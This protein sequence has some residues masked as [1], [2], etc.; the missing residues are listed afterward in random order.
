MRKQKRLE[1]AS[2]SIPERTKSR[3]LVEEMESSFL[4]YSMSVI[5]H[6]AL[7]DVRDG[8]KPVHRRILYAMHDLGLKPGQPYKKSAT[9]VGEV[10]GKYH[11]HGDSAVYEAMVRLAQ[12]FVMAHPL[13]D[14][15]GN[16]GSIDGDSAA[17]YRYTEVRLS[18]AAIAMLEDIERDTVDF[19]PNFDGR[20]EEP[21]VL[22]AR[23][24][25]LLLNGSE[26][27]AVGMATKV[28]PHNLR[29]LGAAIAMLCDQP[30]AAPEDVIRPIKGPDFPTGGLLV[31]G[32]GIDAFKKTGQGLMTLRA[33]AH[34]E[35]GR[36]GN[37]ALV[38]TEI[39]YGVVK[40]NIL[41]QIAELVRGSKSERNRENGRRGKKA[42]HDG[43]DDWIANLRDESD[44]DGIRIVVDLKRNADPATVLERL[45]ARTSL[46]V[47]YGAR[48]L[49]LVNGVPRQLS[50]YEA[51]RTFVEH[52]LEVVARRA[53]HDLA[54]ARDRVHVLEGLLVAIGNIDQVVRIIRESRKRETAAAKLRKAFSL[55]DTQVN[56]ILNLRLAQLTALDVTELKNE[57]A[58]KRK[59]VR[60]LEA[61]LS[62]PSAQRAV[63]K[64]ETLE[65]VERF[66]R[67]RRTN[68][69]H[70]GAAGTLVQREA[71][72]QRELRLSAAGQVLVVPAE[73][74]AARWPRGG[75]IEVVRLR[76]RKDARAVLFTDASM[77]Y[78]LAADDV[79]ESAD[80]PV[81]KLVRGMRKDER[82]LRALNNAEA[83]R[84][85]SVLFVSEKGYVKRTRL[86]EYANPR[87]GGIAAVRIEDDDRLVCVLP[88]AEGQ[89]IV[90]AT[91]LGKAIRFPVAD[92]P[93]QGRVA[94]GVIGIRLAAADRVVSAGVAAEQ[95]FSL[96]A[97]GYGKRTPID[98]FPL[99]RRG[100]QG[101]ILQRVDQKTGP[102]VCGVPVTPGRQR[103]A[104]ILRDRGVFLNPASFGQAER[105]A[106]G[107]QSRFAV[108]GDVLFTLLD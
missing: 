19:R 81:H 5:V 27:I 12:D 90:L 107:E 70:A 59:L 99:Q 4:D 14:G 6:R 17:A 105:S 44:R 25:N 2:P 100:G 13:V 71:D 34:V 108:D 95:V 38:F 46:Q 33:R 84:W 93:V 16:F 79:P 51:L 30:D 64:Q 85:D 49:A 37:A 32:P 61:L 86:E 39:P 69:V 23:L 11:P 66:G 94:R 97:R 73:K 10:L 98:A 31:R 60:S 92:V 43:W 36:S 72:E 41:A 96:T 104:L 54:K 20:H 1:A 28:P 82:I 88:V 55:T 24:P 103:V 87:A 101:V 53:R 29:E 50:L 48:L 58:E 74:R 45:Y 102:V 22:P 78:G 52:R 106:R 68:I 40:A 15:Q 62:D 63:V 21:V 3:S 80:V 26:G 77:A 35:R 57:L 18:E 7:P 91:A 65:L 75:D 9:V 8:L 42:G 47:T 89:E 56:A 67:A 76:L 83:G